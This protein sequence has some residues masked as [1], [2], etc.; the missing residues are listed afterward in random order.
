MSKLVGENL[1]ALFIDMCTAERGSGLP[2]TPEK[3]LIVN[4]RLAECVNRGHLSD[5]QKKNYA[6]LIYQ[7]CNS[8]DNNY[9]KC[10]VDDLTGLISD[11]VSVYDP[12]NGTDRYEPLMGFI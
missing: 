11:C 12:R 9:E 3:I 1:C 2:K 6:L 4:N 8:N 10:I 5:E 7:L